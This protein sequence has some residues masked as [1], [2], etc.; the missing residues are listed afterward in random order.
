MTTTT[1]TTSESV[2]ATDATDIA[3]AFSEGRLKLHRSEFRCN[4]YGHCDKVH[5]ISTHAGGEIRGYIRTHG[6][7]GPWKIQPPNHH[8]AWPELDA[9]VERQAG[10][11]VTPWSTSS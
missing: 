2:L 11:Q 3:A 9:E 7:E 4:Y 8:G 6:S 5:V 10:I 1:T